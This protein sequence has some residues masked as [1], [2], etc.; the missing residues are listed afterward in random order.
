M[1]W[2][3]VPGLSIAIVKQ[4]KVVK[5][6]G[7]GFSNLEDN[8]AA[9]PATVYRIGSVSK[10]FLAAGMMLLVEEGKVRLDDPVS[11]FI[12]QTPLTWK[13]I[14]VRKLLSHTSGI[15]TESPGFDPMKAQPDIEVIRATFPLPLNFVPGSKWEYS[16]VNYYCVAEIIRKVTGEPWSKFI[17]DA[18]LN[19]WT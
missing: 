5:I 3:Q 8:T 2:A 15:V 11:K 4:R 16:N 6:L 1:I 12:D 9:T 14:T 17:E 13:D 18:S 19:P 7:Y 10:Q